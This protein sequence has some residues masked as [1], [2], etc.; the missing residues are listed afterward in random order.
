MAICDAHA[1]DFDRSLRGPWRVFL[2]MRQGKS[3]PSMSLI[4]PF[5]TG[6]EDFSL[7]AEMGPTSA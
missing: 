5:N 2:W 4:L 6:R 3:T 1:T 7:L